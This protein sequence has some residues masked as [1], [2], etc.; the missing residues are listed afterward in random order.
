MASLDQIKSAFAKEGQTI[1]AT[2]STKVEVVETRLGA[3]I[4]K[5]EEKTDRMEQRMDL[6]E[7]NQAATRS[8]QSWTVSEASH[9]NQSSVQPV[10]VVVDFSCEWKYRKELCCKR[11]DA[12]QLLEALK[13]SLPGRAA[14]SGHRY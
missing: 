2:L 12:E 9:P 11:V 14:L 1:T 13:A 8:N 5:V 4:G 6:L 3:C 10:A 7:A